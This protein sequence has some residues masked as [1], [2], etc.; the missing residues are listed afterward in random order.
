MLQIPVQKV[1]FKLNHADIYSGFICIGNL[2]IIKNNNNHIQF[3]A[4]ERTLEKLNW[5]DI[6]LLH[7]QALDRMVIKLAGTSAIYITPG[8]FRILYV[9][10]KNRKPLGKIWCTFSEEWNAEWIE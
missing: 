7:K 2:P 8:P 9:Q 10:D 6:Y 5:F 3:D 1:V 4:S